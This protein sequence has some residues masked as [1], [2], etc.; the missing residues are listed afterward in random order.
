MLK[1]FLFYFV[2]MVVIFDCLA[3]N[4]NLLISPLKGFDNFYVYTT[5]QNV[6]N[7]LYPSNSMYLITKDGVVMFDTPWDTTQFQPLLDS[8]KIKHNKKVIMCIA[9]HHHNDRTIGLEFLREKGIKTFSSNL[10]LELCKRYNEKQ[11]QYVFN[12]DTIFNVGG[13]EFEVYYPGEGHTK[14]NIVI[15]F[16]KQKLLYGGCFIKSTEAN[17]LGNMEDVNV[18]K[19]RISAFNLLKRYPNPE[20]IIPGHLI[21]NKKA[22]KHTIKLLKKY[23]NNK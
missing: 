22:L 1:K 16:P 5:Y 14:D 12:N 6:G 17:N 9:T 20:M 10:T 7:A 21:W 18:K 2:C 23:V 13:Y 8:I 11:A 4:K 3:Q 19:W 15:W